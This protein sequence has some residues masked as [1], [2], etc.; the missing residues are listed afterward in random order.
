M[1]NSNTEK[2]MP[3]TITVPTIPL[4]IHATPNNGYVGKSFTI[5]SDRGALRVE[6]ATI[7]E[8]GGLTATFAGTRYWSMPPTNEPPYE[9]TFTRVEDTCYGAV[10]ET[11][12]DVES[13]FGII[14]YNQRIDR[15][16]RH[17]A[18]LI[19]TNNALREEIADQEAL[20]NTCEYIRDVQE[21][22]SALEKAFADANQTLDYAREPHRK[23]VGYYRYVQST[24][25][26]GDGYYPSEDGLF[27]GEYPIT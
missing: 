14:D 5:E 27:D 11:T 22:L 2:K 16:R 3:W 25:G 1:E 9:T 7:E 17:V 4:L 10:T 15:L 13:G 6:D 24:L 23:A 20:S 21:K 26:A 18:E 8:N 19:Q 12:G